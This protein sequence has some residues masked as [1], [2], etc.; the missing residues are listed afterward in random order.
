MVAC[1]ASLLLGG[2]VRSS[3][4]SEIT[5]TG[6]VNRSL[7]ITVS[8]TGMSG[9][10]K[11]KPEDH[12]ILTN[13]GAWKVSSSTK[14]M[15]TILTASR[16]MAPGAPKSVEYRLTDGKTGKAKVEVGLKTLPNGDQ[17]YTETWTWEGEKETIASEIVEDVSP[18]LNKHLK[19]LGADDQKVAQATEFLSDLVIRIMMGPSDPMLMDIITQPE[20]GLRQF[21]RRIYLGLAEWIEKE[22]PNVD[23]AKAK[24]TAKAWALDLQNLLQEKQTESTSQSNAPGSGGQL[25]TVQSAV[26]GLGQVV[27]TN[28]LLDEVDDR[29]YW[30]MYLEACSN[31]PVVFR[32][33]FRK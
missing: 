6:A 14:D 4:L 17:E 32:A 13:P 1:A 18:I 27:E 3:S 8:D 30:N 20:E 10:N 31:K 21:R 2:C 28:G 25:V 24:A 23:E 26:K 19:P 29:I 15:S 16:T 5:S 12:L 22:V 7:T 33:V 9:E 11:T